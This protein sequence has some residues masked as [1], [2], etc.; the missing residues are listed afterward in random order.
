[1][2]LIYQGEFVFKDVFHYSVLLASAL[3][4][5]GTCAA[6]SGKEVKALAKEA[7]QTLRAGGEPMDRCDLGARLD[8]A[9]VVV[10]TY[11]TEVLRLGDRLLSVNG[12]EITGQATSTAVAILKTLSPGSTIP[13]AIERN[14][15]KSEVPLVCGNSRPRIENLLAGLDAAARGKPQECAAILGERDD[16]GA[17]GSE[18]R[19]RCLAATKGT[20]ERQLA[21]AR[22]VALQDAIAEAHWSR[23]MRERV[24]GSLRRGQAQ[25]TQAMG[26]DRYRTLVRATEQWPGGETLYKDSEPDFAMYRQ[27][28]ERAVRARL[29]DP[30]SARIDMPYGF[31]EGA[32]RPMFQKEVEGYWTCG[33][34]NARNRMGGYAGTSAFVVVLGE[35]GVVKYLELGNGGDYDILA[36]QC[37][38]GAQL[39]P[40]APVETAA[41]RATPAS[42]GAASSLADELK[43][44]S[45]LKASGVLSEAEFEAAKQRI[46]APE[47]KS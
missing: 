24:L 31:L 3:A 27:V 30:D 22:Y 25:I 16:Q 35:S 26:A 5:S 7:A 15:A 34:V 43:K 10:G 12:K 40:P 11:N 47:P 9:A 2:R 13:L 38:K 6:Q 36:T 37:A 19:F 17:F 14:G 21:G 33:T 39:L 8:D 29:I 42:S 18:M 41:A 4:V 23:P 44:L 46:L 45:D 28:T 32:W 1:M 20:Q